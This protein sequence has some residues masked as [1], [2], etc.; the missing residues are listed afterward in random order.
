MAFGN[1]VNFPFSFYLSAFFF[2]TIS[3]LADT[4]SQKHIIV[5]LST[6][7][8]QAFNPDGTLYL[9]SRVCTGMI[10]H[11]T[12]TGTFSVLAKERYHKS[13]L[14]P[15]PIGGYG[16]RGG[17]EM[18]YMIKFSR[19]GEA[20]HAGILP[21]YPNSH[22]CVRVPK[23]KAAKLFRWTGIDTVITIKGETP[24]ADRVNKMR[25]SI[26]KRKKRMAVEYEDEWGA[27]DNM[28]VNRKKGDIMLGLRSFD[29]IG[30]D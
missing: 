11:E 24:Y 3:L 12:P 21:G 2:F 5:N 1:S 14:Y 22:G 4:Y 28:L 25:R 8:M 27:E 29:D 10:G 30:I 26:R 9:E 23:S 19:G 13:N 16:K 18:P 7:K 15:K 6:Q 17:A 20:I